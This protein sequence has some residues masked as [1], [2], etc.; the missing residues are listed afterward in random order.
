MPTE[1]TTNAAN[2]HN[3]KNKPTPDTKHQ[4]TPMTNPSSSIASDNTAASIPTG[5][6]SKLDLSR[7]RVDQ[8]SYGESQARQIVTTIPVRKPSKTAF[9]RTH[10]SADYRMHAGI[11]SRESN[12]ENYL[13]DGDLCEEL[14]GEA[15]FNTCLLVTAITRTG[16]PFIWPLKTG[17]NPWAVSAR[18][19]AE[20][21]TRSWIRLRSDRELGA[22]VPMQAVNQGAEPVWPEMPFDQILELAFRGKIIADMNHPVLRELRGE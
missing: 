17:D 6:F 10:R 8:E 14:M 2:P 12:N 19:A 21:A 16:T 15:A 7:F 1:T 5:E 22:Y 3:L 18:E 9:F 4:L 20:I 11:I 13:V